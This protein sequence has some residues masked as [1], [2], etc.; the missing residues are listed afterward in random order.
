[1]I[2]ID[3]SNVKLLKNKT[4]LNNNNVACQKKTGGVYAF[5]EE[6]QKIS[7]SKERRAARTLGIIMGK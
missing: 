3:K 4:N 1:V 5:I 7:L 6:K 2:E